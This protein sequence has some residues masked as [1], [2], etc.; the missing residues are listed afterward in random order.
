MSIARP[1]DVDV[2]DFES[3]IISTLGE[4]A[5]KRLEG[6]LSQIVGKVFTTNRILRVIRGERISIL[7]G[8]ISRLLLDRSQG[9]PTFEHKGQYR[10]LD[11]FCVPIL[12]RSNPEVTIGE[13]IMQRDGFVK[14]R[15]SELRINL[16]MFSL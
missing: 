12:D 3:L 13:Y 4:P 5:Y 8:F 10:G 2:S 14:W 6:F 15:I 16:R 11:T 1:L 9:K 7:P